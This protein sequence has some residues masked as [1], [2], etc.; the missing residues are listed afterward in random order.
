MKAEGLTLPDAE[1][2]WFLKEKLGLDPLRKQLL[3]TALLGSESYAVIESASALQG[4][5]CSRSSLQ[6]D[7][8]TQTDH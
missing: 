7:G 4:I 8:A 3:E 6:E 5:A 1:L 2:G